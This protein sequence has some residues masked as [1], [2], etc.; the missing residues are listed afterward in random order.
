[1]F[2]G[3]YLDYTSDASVEGKCKVGADMRV[4]YHPINDYTAIAEDEFNFDE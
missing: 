2:T 3:D 1:M 4:S